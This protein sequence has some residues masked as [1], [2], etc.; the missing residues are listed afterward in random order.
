VLKN[1][2]IRK[3]LETTPEEKENLRVLQRLD[4]TVVSIRNAIRDAKTIQTPFREILRDSCGGVPFEQA[5]VKQLSSSR[6][7]DPGKRRKGNT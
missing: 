6:N 5:I 3:V 7:P 1:G 4:S 2:G